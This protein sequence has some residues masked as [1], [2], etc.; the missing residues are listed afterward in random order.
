LTSL[1]GSFSI[2]AC[3]QSSRQRSLLTDI[4]TPLRR[5]QGA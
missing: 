4:A 5:G 2:A 3:L 1:W